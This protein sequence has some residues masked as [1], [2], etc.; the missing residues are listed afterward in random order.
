MDTS[1]IITIVAAVI[2]VATGALTALKAVA[3]HT[4]TVVD[5][6]IVAYGDKALPFAVRVLE[7]L[8]GRK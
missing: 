2:G 3:P 1:T 4:A 6:K 7:W 8:R 5:D